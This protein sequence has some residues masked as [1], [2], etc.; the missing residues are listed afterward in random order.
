[1]FSLFRSAKTYILGENPENRDSEKMSDSAEE[2][3]ISG[4][5]GRFPE[6]DNLA[7]FREHLING[8][9][10]VTEDDRRW[11]PGIMI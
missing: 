11:E 7:E 10:M 8:D 4:F 2:L 5:S 9:D 3:V 6:S 1:L